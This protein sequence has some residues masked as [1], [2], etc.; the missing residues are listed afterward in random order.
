MI[1]R[2]V[3]EGRKIEI[4]S[5]RDV[6]DEREARNV[7]IFTMTRR[8]DFVEIPSGMRRSEHIDGVGG[9]N[10]DEEVWTPGSQN[11]RRPRGI[12]Y[13]KSVRTE[14]KKYDRHERIMESM[15]ASN[16][17]LFKMMKRQK[18]SQDS[19]RITMALLY[20]NEDDPNRK[21]LIKGLTRNAL[22]EDDEDEGTMEPPELNERRN[23]RRE[24]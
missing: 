14:R 11:S 23:S 8:R 19:D 2:E 3:G 24:I 10:D 12:K 16:R 15:T 1:R 5:G 17:M 20:M 22:Q 21:A 6:V 9:P 13:M 4:P 7:N 18:V